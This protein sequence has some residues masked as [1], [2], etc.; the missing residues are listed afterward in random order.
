MVVVTSMFMDFAYFYK[1]IK[2]FLIKLYLIFFI[3]AFSMRAAGCIINDLWDKDIDKKIS[4]TKLR[5]IA[6]G[7]ISTVKALLFLSIL[8]VISLNMPFTT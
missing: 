5:P 8:L 7:E 4:R 6:S 2:H 3:G 1:F